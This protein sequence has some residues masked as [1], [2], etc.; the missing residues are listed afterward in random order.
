MIVEEPLCG[1]INAINYIHCPNV[2]KS[3]KL[4]E[5]IKYTTRFVCINTLICS[6]FLNVK[7]HFLLKLVLVIVVYNSQLWFPSLIMSS[8][9]IVYIVHFMIKLCNRRV[10]KLV[11]QLQVFI[12][13]ELFDHDPLSRF[14]KPIVTNDSISI[15]IK[16]F[17]R[18][19][20]VHIRSYGEECGQW[21]GIV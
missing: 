15:L 21:V 5:F 19:F 14:K 4:Q 7:D 1:I 3:I 17:N 9:R 2:E 20:C 6:N 16:I 13:E 12:I 18:F 8:K 11:V 10:F